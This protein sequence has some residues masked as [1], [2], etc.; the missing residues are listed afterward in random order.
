MN[1]LLD[2]AS[3]V[4]MPNDGLQWVSDL[5][6][7]S[8]V[9]MPRVDARIAGGAIVSADPA[10]TASARATG[11]VKTPYGDFT[12]FVDSQPPVEPVITEIVNEHSNAAGL[13]ETLINNYT[14]LDRLDDKYGKMDPNDIQS[15]INQY[16]DRTLKDEAG[17]TRGA[18]IVDQGFKTFLDQVQ[19]ELEIARQNVKIA[20]DDKDAM[21]LS[22]QAAEAARIGKEIQ[23]SEQA[24]L[25]GITKTLEIGAHVAAAVAA[26]ELE[27]GNV[28]ELTAD[29]F[30]MFSA[31][32]NGWLAKAEK[33]AKQADG[34]KKSAVLGRVSTSLQSLG[35]L[36]RSAQKW[37]PIVERALHD[38]ESKQSTRDSNY[39][40]IKPDKKKGPKNFR[41]D[42]VKKGIA[43]ASQVYDQAMRAVA[44]ASN[45][46][47]LVTGVQ[48][49]HAR[50]KPQQWMA[51]PSQDY[52]VLTDFANAL[53]DMN[54]D[55]IAKVKRSRD[56][57]KIFTKLY[58]DA[59]DAMADAP[60]K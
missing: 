6:K 59:G 35:A 36:Q 37:Q 33:L 11:T 43:L 48:K 27:A 9:P 60:G 51:N 2:G 19:S 21:E 32:S 1:N 14:E 46:H 38:L 4:F 25:E 8:N 55:A 54:Q 45:A 28:L 52:K 41:F 5:G 39:D 13:A 17:A 10:A 49:V 22:D 56:L 7:I 44:A 3:E 31:G 34:L 50:E 24:V 40:G 18:D 57:V 29:F 16:T 42:E 58:G 53:H 47:V 26:P 30:G 12:Y 20:M 23:E 15:E